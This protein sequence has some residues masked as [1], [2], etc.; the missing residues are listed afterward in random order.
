MKT[1]IPVLKTWHTPASDY[2]DAVVGKAEIKTA[3]YRGFYESYGLRGHPFYKAL[4][5]PIRVLTIG[6]EVWMVDDPPHWWAMEDH[7][8][9]FHGHVLVAGLGLGLIVHTLTANPNVERIT[10]VERE[11]DVID[12][13]SPH[14]PHDKLT[15][16]H[17]DFWEWD[18]DNVDGVFFDLFV[19]N[20]KDLM[21]DALRTY[22]HL[23]ERFPRPIRIHGFN[24]DSL[25]KIVS[26]IE[27][28]NKQAQKQLRQRRRMGPAA[29]LVRAGDS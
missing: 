1:D 22:I 4:K 15:I 25:D 14:I 24:N 23:A 11:Q 8:Q 29:R 19:G 9:V 6:G 28:A 2:P 3:H 13:I 20:G 17:G 10:V 7:A 21:F 18:G 16:E 5:I 12:L 27:D 26:G